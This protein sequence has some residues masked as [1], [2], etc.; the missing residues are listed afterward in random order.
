MEKSLAQSSSENYDG[1]GRGRVAVRPGDSHPENKTEHVD[2]G[3][4]VGAVW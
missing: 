3:P 1:N 4:Q 2:T